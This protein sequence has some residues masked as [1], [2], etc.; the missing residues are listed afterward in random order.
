MKPIVIWIT[1]LSGSGKTTLANTLFKNLNNSHVIDGDVLRLERPNLGFSDDDR[2]SNV[3]HATSKALF[4]LMQSKDS[5][6]IIS[7]ISP[8]AQMRRSARKLLETYGNAI[9]IEVYLDVPLDVCEERDPKGLYKKA[10]SG[11]IKNFT[12]IDSLY[13]LPQN[14]DIIIPHTFT[15]EESVEII[16]EKVFAF[17]EN[18]AIL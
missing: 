7:L 1:G 9:F 13:E 6:P 18:N 16:L 8:K 10:R 17:K 15:V 4:L 2:L 12:G 14:P 11:E 5:I 3:L